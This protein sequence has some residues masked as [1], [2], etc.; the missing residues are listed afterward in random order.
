MLTLDED[1]DLVIREQIIATLR[2]GP[3]QAGNAYYFQRGHT[4]YAVQ[5]T[6]QV[7][8]FDGRHTSKPQRFFASLCMLQGLWI[9]ILHCATS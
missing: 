7:R 3:T 9:S 4:G 2:F 1:D 5:K 8:S 6:R